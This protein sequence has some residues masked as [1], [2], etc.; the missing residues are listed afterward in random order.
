[1]VPIKLYNQKNLFELEI[2][3]EGCIYLGGT[4]NTDKFKDKYMEQKVVEWI[5]NLK[6]FS[7]VAAV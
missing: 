7:K 6:V 4:N 3:S 5:N 1:M 2:T